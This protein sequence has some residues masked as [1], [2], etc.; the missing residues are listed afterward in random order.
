MLLHTPPAPWLSPAVSIAVLLSS[1]L[2]HIP[3]PSLH[4][5]LVEA[6]HF[7]SLLLCSSLSRHLSLVLV[8]RSRCILAPLPCS[9]L[10]VCG[11]FGVRRLDPLVGSAGPFRY[12]WFRRPSHWP[13]RTPAWLTCCLL[14]VSLLLSTGLLCDQQGRISSC[15]GQQSSFSGP[16]TSP[17]PCA[18]RW[19]LLRR[20]IKPGSFYSQHTPSICPLLQSSLSPPRSPTVFSFWSGRSIGWPLPPRS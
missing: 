1:Q 13:K 11:A 17:S 3:F 19:L 15:M 10:P 7:P 9:G 16:P 20:C 4:S 12:P 5:V 2:T 8:L 18:P 6:C 14:Q